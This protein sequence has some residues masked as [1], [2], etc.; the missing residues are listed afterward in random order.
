MRFRG[1]LALV[2]LGA[3]FALVPARADEETTRA[4]AAL[5]AVTK[6]G[7]GNEDAGAAWKAVVGKGGAALLP[8]LDAFSDDNATAANWLRAAVD[9]IAEAEKA[10][11]RKLPADQLEAFIKDTT[12]SATARHLA[13]ELLVAQDAGTK[14]KLLPG[15]LNDKSPDLRRDAIG[16]QL[17]KL[18]KLQPAAAK[19]ELE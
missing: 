16:F 10:A 13:Y 15:F 5:K 8:T 9:A 2:V 4:L 1:S 6:E 14:A 7:K 3:L 18:E 12:R 11:G 19:A 17:D